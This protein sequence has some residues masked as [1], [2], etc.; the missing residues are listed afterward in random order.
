MTTL[1]TTLSA[2][3]RSIEAC[4]YAYQLENVERTLYTRLERYGYN[5]YAPYMQEIVKELQVKRLLIQ[6]KHSS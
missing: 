3:S 1:H 6:M 2:I 5:E 4:E